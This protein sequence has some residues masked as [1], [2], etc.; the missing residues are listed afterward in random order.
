MQHALLELS[1][2]RAL[3]IVAIQ[4]AATLYGFLALAAPLILPL[5][6]PLVVL[7]ALLFASRSR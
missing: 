4:I 6:L 2:H 3:L 7:F 5:G 1:L